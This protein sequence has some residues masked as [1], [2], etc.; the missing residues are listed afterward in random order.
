[1]SAG[2][3]SA[4]PHGVLPGVPDAAKG[5]GIPPGLTAA[6]VAHQ[7][8]AQAHAQAHAN[9]AAA[10]HM[11]QQ[12]AAA[13]GWQAWQQYSMYPHWQMQQAAAA[14][15]MQHHH[16]MGY[17]QQAAAAATTATPAAKSG[18]YFRC[19]K[20]STIFPGA[21]GSNVTCTGCGD[22]YSLPPQEAQLPPAVLAGIATSVVVAA[23]AGVDVVPWNTTT[24]RRA[25]PP[26]RALQNGVAT[27]E[28]P[29]GNTPRRVSP[30]VAE[31]ALFLHSTAAPQR[32]PPQ[33]TAGSR[34]RS[35]RSVWDLSITLGGVK[36]GGSAEPGV[37]HLPPD[38][39]TLDGS[40]HISNVHGIADAEEEANADIQLLA[41]SASTPAVQNHIALLQAARRRRKPPAQYPTII[42]VTL[43]MGAEKDSRSIPLSPPVRRWED[44]GGVL[45]AVASARMQAAIPLWGGGSTRVSPPKGLVVRNIA[46]SVSTHIHDDTE[47]EY[48]SALSSYA[49]QFPT[50]LQRA[51]AVLYR[52]SLET[53][54]TQIPIQPADPPPSLLFSAVPQERGPTS[55]P[56]AYLSSL[57][58]AS[59]TELL[60]MRKPLGE[61][62]FPYAVLLGAVQ[63]V[64]GEGRG[65]PECE[66][67]EQNLPLLYQLRVWRTLRG[68]QTVLQCITPTASPPIKA[69]RGICRPLA[70]SE[71][72]PWHPKVHLTAEY[73]LHYA[74]YVSEAQ[75]AMEG[76]GGGVG[77]ARR[78]CGRL[79][80]AEAKAKLHTRSILLAR[81]FEGLLGKVPP[82]IFSFSA[83]TADDGLAAD[84]ALYLLHPAVDPGPTLHAATQAAIRGLCTH[85]LATLCASVAS[86]AAERSIT[87]REIIPYPVVI[88]AACIAA[89]IWTDMQR[90]RA[91]ET[92][93]ICGAAVLSI[94]AIRATEMVHETR[95]LVEQFAFEEKAKMVAIFGQEWQDLIAYARET[96]VMQLAREEAEQE[97]ERQQLQQAAEL[98]AEL[99]RER[100]LE[101]HAA[102]AREYA[103]REAAEEARR[104]ELLR[105]QQAA[106]EAEARLAARKAAE[107]AR[108]EA[109]R[110]REAEMEAQKKAAAE[111][112]VED[113]KRREAEKLAEEQRKL[114]EA[115]DRKTEQKRKAAEAE[116][117]RLR[118]EAER[119]RMTKAAHIASTA[120]V[121][122]II[123]SL[124]CLCRD[125]AESA[126]AA[127]A[128]KIAEEEAAA[129]AAAEA[130]A[131][132]EERLT[133]RLKTEEENSTRQAAP[134]IRIVPGSILSCVSPI[135]LSGP[136]GS[137]SYPEGTLFCVSAVE[138]VECSALVSPFV[139]PDELLPERLVPRVAQ[140]V[141][142][143][144][145]PSTISREPIRLP[146]TTL[147]H[148]PT[149]NYY[150]AL[151]AVGLE[152]FI[153]HGKT[154][155][156]GAPDGSVLEIPAGSRGVVLENN[157][158]PGGG[159]ALKVKFKL[160]R[161][162]RRRAVAPVAVDYLTAADLPASVLSAL[163]VILVPNAV[164]HTTTTS[165][166]QNTPHRKKHKRVK[167]TRDTP[168]GPPIPEPAAKPTIPQQVLCL[169]GHNLVWVP[170]GGMWEA[171]Q[172][173]FHHH[174]CDFCVSEAFCGWFMR[175]RVC[176]VDICSAECTGKFT[177]QKP[178][179]PW[180]A[181]RDDI[182]AGVDWGLL[183]EAKLNPAQVR[184][185]AAHQ[186]STYTPETETLAE[187]WHGS[188]AATEGHVAAGAHHA[189][190]VIPE[191]EIATMDYKLLRKAVKIRGLKAS[192][193]T[194]AL[195]ERLIGFQRG[196]V[197]WWFVTVGAPMRFS[198]NYY[199]FLSQ[200]QERST[201]SPPPLADD[202]DSPPQSKYVL[203]FCGATRWRR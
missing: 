147:E 199:F 26:Q 166:R 185:I 134:V 43:S 139:P 94:V 202:E 168:N 143:R 12:M 3:V 200:V 80:I 33:N 124:E 24:S 132:E 183:L 48:S 91:E 126:A 67:T 13:Q 76:G 96:L 98:A 90:Q 95:E 174:S 127:L 36:I 169:N 17:Y 74:S 29:A 160:N 189:G 51:A 135:K 9:D 152:V 41:T 194:Q 125:D 196:V 18:Q 1:M 4:A 142:Q 111:K 47:P 104:Q 190:Y 97:R 155:R 195:K 176:D 146:I 57:I 191:H 79:V 28:P 77:S 115:E 180:L 50:T 136:T 182:D 145:K 72:T 100:I 27:V 121:T 73:N 78:L 108:L 175:C 87:T 32:T 141:Q 144:T 45:K 40:H 164:P 186:R 60:S 171:G 25:L 103:L 14:A 23:L 128:M 122:S 179:R 131:E 192:G 119:R 163:E 154:L 84:G 53:L 129:R 197:W 52:D 198:F 157:I 61:V 70:A 107:I 172:S 16:Q 201:P 65:V 10:L 120:A 8:Q 58:R 110:A 113:Q 92:L 193:A 181:G 68:M 6:Q 123:A 173:G 71:T 178:Q 203:F 156:V 64:H 101:E 62:E 88:S 165:T 184:L 161:A 83:P 56:M 109:Q 46:V 35:R 112:R 15:Q 117:E 42:D 89:A 133:K 102:A 106:E 5:G 162:D 85:S 105:R 86:I 31:G 158:S 153:R 159:Y 116:Q 150:N 140:Q 130:E 59:G 39:S 34:H 81:Y 167:P 19:T 188:H 54:A 44:G 55:T 7:A 75:I 99:E 21:S 151:F 2:K 66:A 22:S 69:I 170:A 137:L 38:C 11:Q 63:G 114:K 37:F 30:Y 138:K 177:G 20:C 49:A 148:T 149:S 82:Y 187:A 118:L 93:Q